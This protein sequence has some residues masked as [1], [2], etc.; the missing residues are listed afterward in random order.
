MAAWNK[1]IGTNAIRVQLLFQQI[2]LGEYGNVW[3][4]QYSY[5]V[6]FQLRAIIK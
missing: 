6:E 2:F 5:V 1:V 3:I 4:M